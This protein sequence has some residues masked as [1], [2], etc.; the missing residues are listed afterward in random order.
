MIDVSCI[1]VLCILCIFIHVRT[2]VLHV[3]RHVQVTEV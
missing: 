2:D 3:Y 1:K